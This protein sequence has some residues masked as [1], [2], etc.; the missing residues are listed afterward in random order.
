VLV[1]ASLVYLLP[2]DGFCQQTSNGLAAGGT[3]ADAALRALCEVIERD[4]LLFTWLTRRAAP[5]IA[6][7]TAGD[8]VAEIA[9]W[10]AA[11]GVTLTTH[12]LTT[13]TGV[14]AVL[15][16]AHDERGRPP[17]DLIGLGCDPDPHRAV[18]RA[19]LEVVQG[20]HARWDELVVAGAPTTIRTHADHALWY[21]LH[22][23][24]DAFAFLGTRAAP[25]PARIGNADDD[26]EALLAGIVARLAQA[27]HEAV[28][29]E[30]TTLDVRSAGMMVVR[31]L[32]TG[33]LPIHFGVGH[34]RLGSPRLATFPIATLNRT[35]HPL[36]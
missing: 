4:A 27:G 33:L 18:E 20:R 10:Y 25:L 26:T 19:V 14:S 8:A 35:P 2:L 3:V 7:D 31:A 29:A 23:R 36:A 34:E 32:V 5:L 21:A 17:V 9:R 13:T 22:D 16:R 12:D 11:R 24:S 28:I 6:L 1:P 15:A 30:I